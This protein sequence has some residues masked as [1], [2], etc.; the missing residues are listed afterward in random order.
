MGLWVLTDCGSLGQRMPSAVIDWLGAR[1]VPVRA[2]SIENESGLASTPARAAPGAARARELGS[3][4]TVL[5]RAQDPA[6]LV[7][8][9]S[10]Q[11]QRVRAVNSW[12]DIV[13]VRN[14]FTLALALSRSGVPSL[15]S[16]LARRPEDLVDLG[17]DWWPVELHP[18]SGRSPREFNVIER[19]E[20]LEDVE[21]S[22]ITL[23]QPHVRPEDM[24]VT[25]YVA[26][27]RV[28][29]VD[30]GARGDGTPGAVLH[31]PSPELRQVTTRCR[32]ELGLTLFGIGLTRRAGRLVV[33]S[34]CDFPNYER[35]PDAPGVI[36][37]LLLG[38]DGRASSNTR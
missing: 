18:L 26:G 33:A 17:S 24:A 35:V 11:K 25:L 30:D 10:L 23:A 27:D 15:P 32:R 36:G 2:V 38:L 12:S 14:R 37:R 21:W 5:V 9:R 3:T 19:F 29:A 7:T 8:W 13:R 6:T 22:R 16:R 20:Q 4:D 1:G 34:V 28:W 31:T